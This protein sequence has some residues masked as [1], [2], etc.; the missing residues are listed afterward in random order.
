MVELAYEVE[1]VIS[2]TTSHQ[3]M[4]LLNGWARSSIWDR[5]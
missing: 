5:A 4:N 3:S 1:R 2:D